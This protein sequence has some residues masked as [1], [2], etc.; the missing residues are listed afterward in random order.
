SLKNID[1]EHVH[2]EN[3][4]S[5]TKT[6]SSMKNLDNFNFDDQFFNDKPTEEELDK[7]NMETEVESMVT[8]LIH[9]AS[10]SVPP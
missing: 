4:L 2:L 6:L 10:S 5:S 1:E 7:A 8:F 3:P 9:Q